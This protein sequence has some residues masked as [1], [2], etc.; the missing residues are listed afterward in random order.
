MKESKLEDLFPGFWGNPQQ[1]EVAE[2]QRTAAHKELR[3]QDVRELVAQLQRIPKE[4]LQLVVDKIYGPWVQATE[5]HWI[6]KCLSDPTKGF[7]VHMKERASIDEQ[8]V[9]HGYILL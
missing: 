4:D 1:P 5:Y 7:G 6:R 8:L 2:E 3:A 9:K